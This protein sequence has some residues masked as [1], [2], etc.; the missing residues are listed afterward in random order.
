[1]PLFLLLAFA[2][3]PLGASE[4]PAPILLLPQP[5]NVPTEALL[6]VEIPA[7]SSTKYEIR[8]DGHVYVDRFLSTPVVYPANY[9]SMPGTLAGDGDPLDALVLS[10]VSLHPG[11]LVRFR[12]IGVLRMRDGGEEDAKIIG[13]PA[14]DVDPYYAGV[15]DIADLPVMER[16]QIETFFRIYED[17]PDGTEANPVRLQGFGNAAEARTLIRGSLNPPRAAGLP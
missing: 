13:V 11:V 5:V 16:Q 17:L 15:R 14:E 7:G 6:A 3:A 4:P 2:A 1:M 10:P 12:P 9:G 8:E